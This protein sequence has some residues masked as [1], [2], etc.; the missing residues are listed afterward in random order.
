VYAGAAREAVFSN[1]AVIRRINADFVPLALRAPLVNGPQM[2][3]DPDEKWLYERVNRAR[4]APQGIGILTPS[5]QVLAWVQMFDDDQSVL[6]FLDHGLKRARADAAGR[7]LV[8]TERYM[9]FP[10][11]KV[12]EVRDEA[13]LPAVVADA[14]PA[15][16]RC[17]ASGGKDRPPPG[18]L[19]ARLVG[20]A[21]DARGQPVAD[22]VRQEHYVEDQVAITP[23]VL[24]ALAAALAKAGTERVRLPDAFGK[25]CAQ[26]AHLGH[27]D[28]QP[29]LCMIKDRAENKGEWKRCAFW[30]L[31]APGKAGTCWQVEGE[32][33]VVSEVAINGK[34][35]HSVKLAW[36]GFLEVQG[37]R[38]TRLILSARGTEKLQFANDDN[39]LRR[40]RPD[41][42]AFLPA[43]RPID[44]E[45]GVRYA[46]VGEPGPAEVGRE[47]Q[48]PIPEEVRRQVVEALGPP[49]LVFRDKVQDDLRLT[50]EQKQK[51]EE[52]LQEIVPDAMQFF[53][54][55]QDAKPEERVRE[56]QAYQQKAREKLAAFLKDTLTEDQRQ[57]L[58]QLQLQR[59]GP[60]VLGG[61][62]G[63]ELRI[64]D[65][66]RRQFMGVAQDMQKQIEPLVKEAQ[67][68]GNPEDIR[69]RLLKVRKEHEARIVA[70]L[71]DGQKKQWQELL[72][73]P[74]NLDE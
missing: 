56:H 5:G 60:F 24:A 46:I 70:L 30:A 11:L 10:H 26:H 27:I 72:G 52:R 42:V 17:P 51:L 6:D 50:A 40:A 36:E 66:Q 21:L 33:E 74:L 31:P 59:E 37:D 47:E 44:Q 2:V 39:S 9:R 8:V 13:K 53:Q 62:V 32:S 57:R 67:A 4:L 38:V 12:N 69:P 65:E 28:V 61:E 54:K 16:K 1:P 49:F 22:T 23:D 19:V 14:H 43:G 41:E 18:S 55:L 71:T 25:A 63:K 34:G 3:T 48:A 15:G 73:K 58:R 64:T 7:Q 29:C 45:S 68:G 35:V 20:R